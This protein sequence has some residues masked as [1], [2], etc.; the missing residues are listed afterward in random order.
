MNAIAV[1]DE[2]WSIG[3]EGGLLV[4]LPG[5][6][7]CFKEKTYGKTILIGRKTLESFP[8]K[9]PLAGRRNIVLT[10]QENYAAEGCEICRCKEQAEEL[11]KGQTEDVFIAGGESVYRA[12]LA[13]CDA[14]FLTK[15][16]ASFPADRF[17]PNLDESGEFFIA[18]KSA[19]QEE[20]G[21]RYQFFQYVRKQEDGR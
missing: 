18:W 17:F 1:V 15:I 13:D 11:L 7:K 6:L 21:I 16:Y 14:V 10:R 19:V 20:K 2:N 8:G 9:K 12:F 3:R 5:D 4:H